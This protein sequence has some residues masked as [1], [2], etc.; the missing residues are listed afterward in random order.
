M[1]HFITLII[2]STALSIVDSDSKDLTVH[3]LA[4]ANNRMHLYADQ[5]TGRIDMYNKN[6]NGRTLLKAP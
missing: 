1:K 5:D 3:S 6:G 2:L 4:L